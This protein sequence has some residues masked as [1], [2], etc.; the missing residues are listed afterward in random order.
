MGSRMVRMVRIFISLRYLMAGTAKEER[1]H[2]LV[3]AEADIDRD[4][5]DL[6]LDCMPLD[7][8]HLA[9]H[10]LAILGGEFLGEHLD[11]LACFHV[12]E[13]TGLGSEVEVDLFAL[14]DGVEEDDFVLGMAKMAE[15]I[16]QIFESARSHESVGK[17]YDHGT[18]VHLLRHEV[19][20]LGDGGAFV[21]NFFGFDGG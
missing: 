9:V 16:V 20:R 8:R 6:I 14:V 10:S 5:I 4:V 12:D 18:A 21:L 11:F 15:G 1:L 19:E 13:E 7:I 17:D 2:D 3:E